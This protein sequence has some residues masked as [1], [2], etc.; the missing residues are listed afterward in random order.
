MMQERAASKRKQQLR[1]QIA[2][3]QDMHRAGGWGWEGESGSSGLA[4]PGALC[5]R[6]RGVVWC[7]CFLG[8]LHEL[9]TSLTHHALAAWP[10]QSLRRPRRQEQQ[11]QQQPPAGQPGRGQP[12]MRRPRCTAQRRSGTVVQVLLVQRLQW[13]RRDEG[14]GSAGQGR[15]GGV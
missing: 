6:V 13:P 7:A 10:A 9:N 2:D 14:A 4:A 15:G 12:A 1:D 11:Q 8:G 3:A 5:P